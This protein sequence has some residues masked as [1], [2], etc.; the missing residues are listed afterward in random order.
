MVVYKTITTLNHEQF[1]L[2]QAEAKIAALQLQLAEATAKIATL[3]LQL[4][5]ARAQPP[6]QEEPQRR[7]QGVG[8]GPKIKLWSQ[9]GPQGRRIVLAPVVD[10]LDKLSETRETETD[11]LAASILH[12]YL[13]LFIHTGLNQLIISQ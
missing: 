12:R 11:K 8:G 3:Q 5:E 9:L 2:E 13:H 7:S 4:A 6:Q 10:E 1:E